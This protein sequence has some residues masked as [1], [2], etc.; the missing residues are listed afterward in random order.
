MCKFCMAEMLRII[1]Q[2][3]KDCSKITDAKNEML[4]MELIKYLTCLID[5]SNK[6]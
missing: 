4:A 3:Q 5:R 6:C 1:L 2:N